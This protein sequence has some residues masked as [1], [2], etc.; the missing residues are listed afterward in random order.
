MVAAQSGSPPAV[1]SHSHPAGIEC[2]LSKDHLL[3]YWIL[4]GLSKV[5]ASN[6]QTGPV[7]LHATLARIDRDHHDQIILPWPGHIRIFLASGAFILAGLFIASR[8]YLDTNYCFCVFPLCS[9]G[10][11]FNAAELIQ[12][13]RPV[14]SG[15]PSGKTCPR[16]ALQRPQSTSVRTIKKPRSSS[17]A[18]LFPTNGVSKLGHPVP[19]S[20]LFSEAKRGSSQQTHW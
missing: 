13:R 12:Y 1:I 3:S 6:N 11:N 19:E 8:Q 10:S 20:N 5:P 7:V 16:C 14:V 2:S 9:F 18:T 4:P 17:S 15:G